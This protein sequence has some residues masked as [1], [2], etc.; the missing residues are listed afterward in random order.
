MASACLHRSILLCA[1]GEGAQFQDCGRKERESTLQKESHWKARV[2]DTD[3]GQ[4]QIRRDALRGSERLLTIGMSGQSAGSLA[5]IML[6]DLLALPWV[7]GSCAVRH[8]GKYTRRGG[9]GKSQREVPA[10]RRSGFDGCPPSCA[11]IPSVQP[12]CAGIHANHALV[13]GRPASR[14]AERQPALS[15]PPSRWHAHASH[16]RPLSRGLHPGAAVRCCLRASE[17]STRH[18]AHRGTIDGPMGQTG[19]R[20]PP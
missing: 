11:G 14:G 9:W 5:R 10:A 4:M 15:L 8:K 16:C 6:L 18:E 19:C 20:S 2:P 1:G 12:S 13:V 7:D 17:R 3:R